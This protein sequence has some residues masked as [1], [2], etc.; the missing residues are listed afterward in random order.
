MS[1]VITEKNKEKLDMLNGCEVNSWQHEGTVLVKGTVGVANG[2][3]FDITNEDVTIL[4]EAYLKQEG[5]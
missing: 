2:D 4:W 3:K 1:E 5:F